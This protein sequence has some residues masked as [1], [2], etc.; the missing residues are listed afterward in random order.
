MIR[1][2]RSLGTQER[3]KETKHVISQMQS[4]QETSGKKIFVIEKL[5]PNI[6]H[7]GRTFNTLPPLMPLT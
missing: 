7:M 6:R 3:Q 4:S 2:G 1:S 5:L